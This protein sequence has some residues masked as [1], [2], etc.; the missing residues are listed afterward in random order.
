MRIEWA[1][2]GGSKR[3]KY[4]NGNHVCVHKTQRAVGNDCSGENDPGIGYVFQ[5]KGFIVL[6]LYITCLYTTEQGSSPRRVGTAR[7]GVP[8]TRAGGP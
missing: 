5:S 2:N 7:C 1:R 6:L 8:S 3:K 4:K